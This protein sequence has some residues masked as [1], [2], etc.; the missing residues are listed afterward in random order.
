MVAVPARIPLITVSPTI[1]SSYH[2]EAGNRRALV[3]YGTGVVATCPPD[4]AVAML[5]LHEAIAA[6]GGS[7]YVTA[8]HRPNEVSDAAHAK[9]QRWKRDKA[10]GKSFDPT[11]HKSAYAAPGGESLH[12]AARATDLHVVD[13][14]DGKLV[15]VMF[16]GLPGDQQ[17]D[18]LWRLARPLGFTPIISK[19][20]ERA[21]EHWHLDFLGPWEATH[22][23]LGAKQAAMAACLDIGKGGYG[24]DLERALQAQLHR[25]GQDVGKIDGYIGAKTRGGLAALGLSESTRDPA[26]L[27]DLPTA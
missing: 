19:P 17:V 1:Q 9:Y 18:E 15:P 24:R 23:R 4:V 6:A 2:D 26:T 16:P 5:A 27:F 14:A 11:I 22:A 10:A 8:L 13:R 3:D 12:N 21:S 7:M 25:C 20:N